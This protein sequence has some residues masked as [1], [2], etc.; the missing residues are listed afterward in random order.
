MERDGI[1]PNKSS[2]CLSISCA[3][4]MVA[5]YCLRSS[6]SSEEFKRVPNEAMAYPIEVSQNGALGLLSQKFFLHF[7]FI[8]S[9]FGLF[10]IYLSEGFGFKF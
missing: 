1:G 7:W 6:S 4:R 2:I 8:F 3:W 5:L 9:I 10:S